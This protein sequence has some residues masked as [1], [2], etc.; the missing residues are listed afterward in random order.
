MDAVIQTDCART[1]RGMFILGFCCLSALF[2]QRVVPCSTRCS[3]GF[4]LHILQ[5]NV[6]PF[7]P[8]CFPVAPSTYSNQSA[9][10][11]IGSWH[12]VTSLAKIIRTFAES[13][14]VLY[15]RMHVVKTLTCF[16]CSGAKAE[17]SDVTSPKAVKC[18][19]LAERKQS[20]KEQVLS[21]S[22]RDGARW[23]RWKACAIEGE[24]TWKSL[25]GSADQNVHLQAS[26]VVWLETAKG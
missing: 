12:I 10:S 14:A 15:C 9:I 22:P 26:G 16:A 17:H 8:S 2:G 23:K 21:H 24:W 6:V 25:S 13:S 20:S 5:K 18:C 7:L 3:A 19:P 1:T 4:W 11:V